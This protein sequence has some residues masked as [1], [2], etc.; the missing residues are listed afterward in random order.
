[1]LVIFV[2]DASE[3]MIVRQPSGEFKGLSAANET[4]CTLRNLKGQD[5]AERLFWAYIT[6]H[7][8]ARLRYPIT[9]VNQF[10]PET[11]DFGDFEA[12]KCSMDT[13]GNRIHTGFDLAAQ[14]ASDFRDDAS[15]D[16]VKSSVLVMMMSTGEC[17][18]PA[19]SLASANKLKEAGATVSTVAYSAAGEQLLMECASPGRYFRKFES[20][21]TEPDSVERAL[22]ISGPD[23]DPEPTEPD[24]D[25]EGA[26]R[27]RRP[28]KAAAEEPTE[29]SLATRQAFV[30]CADASPSMTEPFGSDR[31]AASKAAEV[32]RVIYRALERFTTHQAK[33]YGYV[34]FDSS[35]F[36]RTPL[37]QAATFDP[38]LTGPGDLDPTACGIGTGP[39]RIHTGL[40]LA[41][42]MLHDFIVET[43]E[44][45]ANGAFVYLFTNGQC[46]DP[47]ETIAAALRLKEA[48]AIIL[49]S[50]LSLEG[51]EFVRACISDPALYRQLG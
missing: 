14:L 4:F 23:P 20:E 38:R 36:V 33:E 39:T 3:G 35:A 48:G 34:T 8:W 9:P 31:Y 19:A 5:D 10:D 2:G 7:D 46:S 17:L 12:S 6:F 49:G 50:A 21:P 13:G 43:A 29:R 27:I 45:L 30:F 37:T 25:Q 18:N 24:A 22:A 47:D 26:S 40:D 41:G 1:V 15:S 32:S 42:V 11:M 51:E 16:G 28:S 44:G